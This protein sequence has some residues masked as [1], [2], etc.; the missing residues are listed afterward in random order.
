MAHTA[1]KPHGQRSKGGLEGKRFLHIHGLN[2]VAPLGAS[3]VVFYR[4]LSPCKPREPAERRVDHPPLTRAI[5][6]RRTCKI[7]TSPSPQEA[8]WLLFSTCTIL[9]I[10]HVGLVGRAGALAPRGSRELDT[11]RTWTASF[12]LG[13]RLTWRT[14]ST[15]NFAGNL[16]G[17]AIEASAFIV[18]LRACIH[19][20]VQAR[21][22]MCGTL[23]APPSACA[24]R[25]R[26]TP[27]RPPRTPSTTREHITTTAMLSCCSAQVQ[28]N[29]SRGIRIPGRPAVSLGRPAG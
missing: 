14:S 11:W 7:D 22:L 21:S 13:G 19:F 4:R 3:K 24:L 8:C 1:P 9:R 15:S 16:Q 12:S 25:A 28:R 5:S 20:L 27:T 26:W 10:R 6:T 29:G 23:S 18:N 2:R 17:N